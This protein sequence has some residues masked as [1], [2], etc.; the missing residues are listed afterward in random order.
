MQPF[1]MSTHQENGVVLSLPHIP[2]SIQS[3]HQIDR[4]LASVSRARSGYLTVT[5][6][7][8][9]LRFARMTAMGRERT[10][11]YLLQ[12]VAF[13]PRLCGNSPLC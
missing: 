6:L 2:P 10:G 12:Y 1:E 3:T 11:V 7:Q 9:M 13:G 5:G 8:E 4:G